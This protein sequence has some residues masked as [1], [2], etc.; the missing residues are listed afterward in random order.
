MKMNL[1]KFKLLLFIVFLSTHLQLLSSESFNGDEFKGTT[2]TKLKKY[3]IA[4]IAIVT[5]V[6]IPVLAINDFLCTDIN[7]TMNS[8]TQQKI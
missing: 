3:S 7:N 5:S 4:G 1:S 2:S 6:A 8:V